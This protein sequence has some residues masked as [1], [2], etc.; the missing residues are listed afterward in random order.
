LASGNRPMEK[1]SGGDGEVVYRLL[2]S[3][4]APVEKLS[5]DRYRSCPWIDG[6]VVYRSIPKLSS[7]DGEVAH[8]SMEKLSAADG[9]VV[10]RPIDNLKNGHFLEFSRRSEGVYFD[11]T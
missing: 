10:Y 2:E 5:I 3:C 8:G 9:E 1:L 6:E 11:G 4:L 7:V